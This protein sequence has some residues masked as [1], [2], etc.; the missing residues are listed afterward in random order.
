MHEGK[1]APAALRRGHFQRLALDKRSRIASGDG[2]AT[3][4]PVLVHESHRLHGVIRGQRSKNESLTTDSAFRTLVR[5]IWPLPSLH[6]YL[7]EP[8]TR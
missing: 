3:P 8:L 4:L 1:A 2:R 6:L 5:L 7:A